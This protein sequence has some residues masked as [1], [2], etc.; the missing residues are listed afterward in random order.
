MVRL[1]IPSWFERRHLLL[2]LGLFTVGL[3]ALAFLTIAELVHEGEIA[4]I[5]RAILLACR[6]DPEGL[7]PAGP[8]WLAKAAVELT[9]LG[10]GTVATII[11]VIAFGFLVLAKKPKLGVL[12]VGACAGAGVATAVLKAVYDRGRPNV[13]RVVVP[14]DGLSF[15]SGHATISVALY[16]TLAAL[17]AS[18]LERRVLRVYVMATSALLALLI[19]VSRVYIGVHYPSDVLAGWTLGF[20]WALF[21]GILGRALE[22]RG[23][24]ERATDDAP[25]R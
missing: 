4:N 8:P 2:L 11:A 10:S 18:S 20:G 3:L 21:C 25:W 22:Q 17:I 19:G 12:L 7:V 24:I 16:L 6:K 23:T 9:A 15:P 14:E 5:D 13:T 1:R